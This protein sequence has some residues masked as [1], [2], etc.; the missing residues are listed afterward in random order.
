[1]AEAKRRGYCR[2]ELQVQEDNDRAW[3]LY[4]ARGYHFTG[5]LVYALDFEE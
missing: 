4:E 3:K 5:Y 2:I 1:M